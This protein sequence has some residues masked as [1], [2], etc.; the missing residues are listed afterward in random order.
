MSE[1]HILVVPED[2]EDPLAIEHPDTCPT[3]FRQP[4]VEAYECGVAYHEEAT[5]IDWWFAH[6]DDDQ[7][8]S[9][10]VTKLAPGTYR[11]EP[12]SEQVCTSTPMHPAE[13]D[14]GLRVV[15]ES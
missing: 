14:G 15:E 2:P 5:G 10:Y 8:D 6:E 4:G 3:Y 13:W 7:A 11:I 12:W 9:P 1:D